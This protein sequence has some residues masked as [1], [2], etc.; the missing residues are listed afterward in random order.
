MPTG[1]QRTKPEPQT[2]YMRQQR[3]IDDLCRLCREEGRFAF[4]TEF[5][6]EDRFEPEVCLIQIATRESIFV[7]DPFCKIDLEAIWQLIGDQ[8]VETVVHAGQ[9]D[10]GFCVQQTGSPPRRIVDVQIAAGLAGFDYPASLAKLVRQTLHVRLHK[11]KTLTDW[12]KRPL[13][14]AQV[15]Y[16]MEDVRYLLSLHGTL[17]ERLGRRNR[18][19]WAEEEFRRFEDVSFYRRAEEEKLQRVKGGGSLEGQAL[20]IL[21][22]LLTWRTAAAKRLNR[23]V[24]AVLKDHLLVEIAKH[25][26]RSFGEIRDLR[27]VNLSS[28]HVREVVEVVEHAL[29]VPPAEWPAPRPREQERPGEAALIALASAVVRSF[30][31]EHEIAYALA[32]SKDSLQRLVRHC[33]DEGAPRQR[34]V[35]L[36]KG[37]R[38]AAFG[39]MLEEVLAGRRKLHVAAW[40]GERLVRVE[41]AVSPAKGTRAGPQA[42]R[43]AE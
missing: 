9:E 11:S 40:R 16:A 4:D 24:R 5:V 26:L 41:P 30:C 36:L 34:K 28:R 10:L 20:V 3:G 23:P 29:Q 43:R 25:K 17:R 22:E 19:A 13:T 12:R 27:G 8:D 35:E 2:H 32:A 14:D 42:S 15:R 38:G 1:M 33:G 21:R 31:L 6:M 7:I 37:W 39:R 18:L